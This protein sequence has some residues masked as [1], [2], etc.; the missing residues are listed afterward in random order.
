M[1]RHYRLN[2]DKFLNFLAGVAG[3]LIVEACVF[4]LILNL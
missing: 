1:K 4:A 2:K 3:L